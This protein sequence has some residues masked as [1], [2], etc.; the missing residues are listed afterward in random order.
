MKKIFA[1]FMTVLMFSGSCLADTKQEKAE[2]ILNLI[3][4]RS[5][6]DVAYDQIMIPVSCEIIMSAEEE[7]EFKKEFIKIADVPSLINDE[8]EFWVQNY[9]EEE[10]DQLLAFYKTDL[11]KK[12][13]A[14]MPKYAQFSAKVMQKWQQ[15]KAP[16]IVE[17]TE[18]LVQKHSRRSGEETQACI[19]SKMGL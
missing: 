9:T 1:V 14:L 8:M 4:V 7:A 19:R 2:E 3:N 5:A 17:L 12:N 18:I 6:V 13:I 15:Q 11:G 16:K 10:L